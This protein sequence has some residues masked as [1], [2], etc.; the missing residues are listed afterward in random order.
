MLVAWLVL[1]AARA[2]KRFLG[3]QGIGVLT[4][5]MGFILVCI[6]VQFVGTAL[7]DVVT[8]E[9]LLGAIAAALERSRAGS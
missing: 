1:S 7:I 4:R 5:I 9:R 3:E 6:G 8:N 2:V